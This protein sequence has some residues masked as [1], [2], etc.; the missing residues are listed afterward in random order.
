MATHTQETLPPHVRDMLAAGT[1]MIAAQTFGCPPTDRDGVLSAYRLRAEQV[2]AE[3]APE[4]LLVFDVA[5]GWAPLCAF[6]GVAVPDEAFPRVN[7]T[8]D[9]W[10][11]VRGEPN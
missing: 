1:E 5:E 11:L 6:L 10:K 8:V 9:F 4:R 3:I 2:R 7:S